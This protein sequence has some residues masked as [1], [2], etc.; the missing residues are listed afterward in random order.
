MSSAPTLS[1]QPSGNRKDSPEIP[2]IPAELT[3]RFL[4]LEPELRNQ[5][6]E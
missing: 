5:I 2:G 4:D 6:Y 1:F 3:F